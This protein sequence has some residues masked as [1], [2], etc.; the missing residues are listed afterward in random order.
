MDGLL[1]STQPTQTREQIFHTSPCQIHHTG[2]IQVQPHSEDHHPQA[3]IHKLIDCLT[4]TIQ[5]PIYGILVI[6]FLDSRAT[7]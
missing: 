7:K 1:L 6:I 5:I 4:E 2:L 3:T